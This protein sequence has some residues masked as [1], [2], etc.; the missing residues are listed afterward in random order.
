MNPLRFYLCLAAIVLIS[1]CVTPNQYE[2]LET[3]VAVIE[4]NNSRRN[5][6]DQTN[7]DE[8]GHLKQLVD[9][10]SKTARENYAEMKYDIQ[11]LRDDFHKTQSQIEEVSGQ[12]SQES[13]E[14]MLERLDNA[15]SRNY[16]KIVALEKYMGF[17]PSVSGS[18]GQNN[19]SVAGEIQD[20]EDG[21]YRYAKKLLDQGDLESARLQFE[22]FI[23]KYP[24]S[25]NADNAR[26]WIADSYYAEKWYEKAILEYQKVLENYPNSNKN[27]AARLKQGYAFV[28]LGEKANARLILKELI[29][30]YPNSQEAK[31]A[32][33]KLKKIN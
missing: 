2:V 28:A 7:T 13:L 16:E 12:E 18:P 23:S 17:E 11:Q 3:R 29:T 27:A 9:E 15:I 1:G 26:F 4:Q 31:Y 8:L 33:E 22:N 24:D 5:T 30:R 20:T 32:S 6:L 14:K 25:Q 21:L 10:F 19:D